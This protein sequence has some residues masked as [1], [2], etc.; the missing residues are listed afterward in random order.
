MKHKILFII[1]LS[2]VV[3]CVQAQS[4][5]PVSLILAKA[6][7]ALDLK[8]QRLQN[9]TMVLQRVQ[10][11]AENELSKNKLAEI[12]NWQ[13]QLNKLYEG[14]YAELRQVKPTILGG[15]MVR[16][17]LSLQQQLINEYGRVGK[18]TAVKPQ[19]DALLNSSMEVLD[20]LYVVTGSELSMKDSDRL[21][22]LRTLYDAMTHCLESMQSLNKR[23]LENIVNRT[24]LQ[25]DLDYVKRLHG[26]K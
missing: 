25:A 2:F 22:V 26:L 15:S 10:Q 6:I 7:K 4:I 3:A 16:R 17:I 19:Y 13:Q 9:E 21:C 8:I 20:M 23:E 1:C 11:A 5:D 14:Y 12:S 24:R 18:T